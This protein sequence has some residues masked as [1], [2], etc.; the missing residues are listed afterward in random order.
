[1]LLVLSSIVLGCQCG[2]QRATPSDRE[3]SGEPSPSAQTHSETS[4]GPLEL[5][6][7][8]AAAA[9]WTHEPAIPPPF[10]GRRCPSEMVDVQG[11]FCIDR[12]EAALVDAAKERRISPYYHPTRRQTRSSFERWEQQRFTMGPQEYQILPLPVPPRFQRTEVFEVK[13]K[14]ERGVVPNGYLNGVLAEQACLNAGKRLCTE[15]EWET[16]CRGETG[17]PFPYGSEY[18]AGEC[19]VH[20]GV[21]PAAVLHGHASLGH[22]DPRL[23]H[24]PYQGRPLLAPTG[25]YPRCA[26]RWGDDAV[27]DMVGNL[28]EWVADEDGV[29]RGGFYARNTKA[30]CEA[31]ISSHPRAYFD[32]SLGVR[33]CR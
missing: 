1:M 32:Y 2:E 19:N 15:D 13:A 25:S 30:G 14:S 10:V 5:Y 26:S 21:H 23:N 22:L 28:D 24:F 8:D 11:Q 12:F 9:D 3:T 18:R 33:C 4:T 27:Y 16:A 29:F 7:P 20:I 17:E 6:I 31:R